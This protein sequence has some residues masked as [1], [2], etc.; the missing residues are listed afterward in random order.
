V[1]EEMVDDRMI[2]TRDA[3]AGRNHYPHARIYD[4]LVFVTSQVGRDPGSGE[5]VAGGF[6]PEFRQALKNVDAILRAAGSS[7]ER[8][9]QA[10]VILEDEG[11]FQ[12][13]NRIY[14]ETIQEPWPART[15]FVA[16]LAGQACCAISVVA[17]KNEADNRKLTETT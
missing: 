8:L 5:L 7:M 11:D 9:L 17:T 13:M 1:G 14:D 10:T 12:A 15:S 6:E 4:R 16:K 2:V 3:P